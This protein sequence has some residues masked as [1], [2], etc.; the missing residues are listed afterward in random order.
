MNNFDK[1]KLNKSQENYSKN[2]K[3]YN[4]NQHVGFDDERI[5]N[6]K[7]NN[8]NYLAF[9][10]TNELPK[11]EPSYVMTIELEKGKSELIQI[12][13]DSNPDE[14]AFEFCKKNNLNL[15]AM[16]FLSSEIKDLLAK[17]TIQS[18]KII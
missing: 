9:E 6:Y 10:Q 18:C 14:L 11:K 3:S 8:D 5:M 17:I 15:N 4:K 7:D 12:F 1:S 13:I 16:K 2:H